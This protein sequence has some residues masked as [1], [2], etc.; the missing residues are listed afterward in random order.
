MGHVHITSANAS[1]MVKHSFDKAFHEDLET[2]IGFVLICARALRKGAKIDATRP[3]A[4]GVTPTQRL[5]DVGSSV[6]ALG[7]LH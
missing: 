7:A 5:L 6:Y 3:Q 4:E 1:N 2:R